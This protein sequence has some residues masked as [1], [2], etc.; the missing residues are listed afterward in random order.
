M[1]YALCGNGA[2]KLLEKRETVLYMME[3][4]MAMSNCISVQIEG[5]KLAQCLVINEQGCSKMMKMCCEPIVKSIING[6]SSWSSHSGKIPKDQ[7]ALLVEVCRLA[8]ITRWAG[9]HHNYFWKLGIGNVLL[10][11]LLN[12]FHKTHQPQTFLSLEEQIAT[13]QKGLSANF[14][15]VL[16]PFIWDILGGLA[17][18]C[19]EDVNAKMHGDEV[20]VNLLITFCLSWTQFTT[21]VSYVKMI[22]LIYVGMNQHLDQFL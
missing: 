10:N 2:Q 8:L 16:R 19:P 7:M 12:N 1:F 15:L 6:L 3:D 22:S 14:L 9:E 20:C 13:A 18:H 17:A 21:H 4:C 5:F 11:L